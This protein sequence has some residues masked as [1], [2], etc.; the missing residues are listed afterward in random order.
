MQDRGSQNYQI[1]EWKNSTN[2]LSLETINILWCR[3]IL[4]GQSSGYLFLI[5]KTTVKYFMRI[6]RLDIIF[7]TLEK[8]E[9]CPKTA[10]KKP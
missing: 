10:N 3:K 6:S 4:Y 2:T 8:L 7:Q 9:V 1:S 5:Y